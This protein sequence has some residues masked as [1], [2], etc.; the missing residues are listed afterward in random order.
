MRGIKRMKKL[1]LVFFSVVLLATVSSCGKKQEETAD[2]YLNKLVNGEIDPDV[3]VEDTAEETEKTEPDDQLKEVSESDQG[4]T[5][6]LPYTDEQMGEFVDA[7]DKYKS[8]EILPLDSPDFMI[9]KQ[10]RLVAV[11]QDN[12]ITNLYSS[13]I[14]LKFTK[15][16]LN[17]QY[18]QNGEQVNT[19]YIVYTTANEI[20][21]SAAGHQY[22]YTA[23][24]S[25]E[26]SS[27]MTDGAIA[28]INKVK[29][30]DSVDMGE[31]TA[32]SYVL[33]Q[34]T[35]NPGVYEVFRIEE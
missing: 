5:V 30:S 18:I 3:K 20:Q 32:E 29:I 34:E 15:D 24:G 11:I 31:G 23:Y 25:E 10:L 28:I 27:E 12:T 2:S 14:R 26:I 13:E 22:T 16:T 33:L 6:N 9:D 35:S 1:I 8:L 21:T 7:L 19:D 4:V 17:M